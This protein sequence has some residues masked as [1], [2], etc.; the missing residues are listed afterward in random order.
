[1]TLQT[2][3][4]TVFELIRLRLV[5]LGYLPDW[6]VIAGTPEERNVIYAQQKS[7]IV[8]GGSKVIEIFGVGAGLSKNGLKVPLITI[9]RK[10]ITPGSI[11]TY[12]LSKIIKTDTGYRKTAYLSNTSNIE[13][14]VRSLTGTTRYER[15]ITDIMFGLFGHK[16]YHRSITDD[17]SMTGDVIL[18]QGFNM[19]DMSA[20]V[21]IIEKV[22]TFTL[23]DVCIELDSVDLGV[24]IVP[25]TSITLEGVFLPNTDNFIN[26]TVQDDTQ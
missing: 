22:Y 14:E 17:R 7:N 21:D 6:S 11:G 19:M 25:L 4:R 1:M 12:G 3:D 8:S 9:N 10:R 15:I 20:R 2:I 26:F 23:R 5:A 16:A 18:F 24:D 13:F